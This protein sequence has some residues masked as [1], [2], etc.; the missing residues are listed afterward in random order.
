MTMVMLWIWTGSLLRQGLRREGSFLTRGPAG[1]AAI[2]CLLV[3]SANSYYTFF[4]CYLLGVAAAVSAIRFKCAARLEWGLGLAALTVTVLIINT[5]PNWLYA[6]RHGNNP[7]VA[8][9]APVEAEIYGLKMTHLLLPISSHRLQFLRDTRQRYDRATTDGEGQTA[10]LGMIGDIG[11]VFL[12]GWMVCS[13]R[14]WTE[15]DILSGLAVLIFA[16]LL[17]GTVGG[18]GSVFN[19]LI[20]PQIRAYNR[21]SIYIAFFSLFSVALLL[22]ALK[23]WIG[24]ATMGTYLWYGLL[25]AVLCLGI[26]DQTSPSFAK[27]YAGL[28]D[29]YQREQQ[30]ISRI[31]TSIAKGAMIFELPNV[32]FPEA[33]PVGAMRGYDE[34]RG[35]LHSRTLRWSAGAIRGRPEALWTERNGLNLGTEQIG[36]P[37]IG[38]PAVVVQLPL[39]AVCARFRGI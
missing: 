7:V 6:M 17:L 28:K 32:N 16:A 14:G 30:F 29:R 23:R 33:K 34:L 35:Y 18:I 9:R 24:N 11:F 10:S 25:G 5:T 21:I 20:Y 2:I 4:G 1:M 39:Q 12:L 3:G 36:A 8:E 37:A 38:N 31:K 13:P 27:D 15:G 19:F 22:D 26:L